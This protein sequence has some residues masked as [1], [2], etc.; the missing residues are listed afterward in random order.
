MKR[1]VFLV[2]AAVMLA[3]CGSSTAP[4]NDTNDGSA[5]DITIGTGTRPTYTWPGGLGFSVS[6]VRVSAP[7][8]IVWG[9]ANPAQT[10]ASPVTHGT[11]PGGSI[12]SANTEPT[13]TAGVKYRV[14]ITRADTKTGF[15]EFTP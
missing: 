6:V 3:G 8:T 7:G 15:K 11:V 5:F 4:S 12:A 9:I 13:L 10:I 14:A 1:R 2:A